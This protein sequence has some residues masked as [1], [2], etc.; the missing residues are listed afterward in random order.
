MDALFLS[1]AR[2]SLLKCHTNLSELLILLQCLYVLAKIWGP[3]QSTL[4]LPFQ[5][6]LVFD[7]LYFVKNY[8]YFFKIKNTRKQNHL[9]KNNT[10]L[11]Y[12]VK[13]NWQIPAPFCR[14]CKSHRMCIFSLSLYTAQQFSKVELSFSFLPASY[15]SFHLSTCFQHLVLP[16]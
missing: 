9:K 12:L 10:A 7:I 1:Q 5:S 4:K 2:L 14:K 15:E 11:N 16:V 13:L 3:T 8:I 6:S